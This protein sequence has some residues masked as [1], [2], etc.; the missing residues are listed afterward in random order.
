MRICKMKG[1][2]GIICKKRGLSCEQCNNIALY[3]NFFGQ[4]ISKVQKKKP[5]TQWVV[6]GVMGFLLFWDLL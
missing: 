2:E 3:G 5:L 4:K 1:S 6:L